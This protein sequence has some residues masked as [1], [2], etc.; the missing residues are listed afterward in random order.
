MQESKTRDQT[1]A[2]RSGNRPS[3]GPAPDPSI[4]S[5]IRKLDLLLLPVVTLIYF[6]NFLDR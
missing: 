5:A 1:E 3:P 4:N 2:T 6:L